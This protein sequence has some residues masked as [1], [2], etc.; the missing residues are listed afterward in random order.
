LERAKENHLIAAELGHVHSMVEFSFALDESDPLHWYWFGK[1]TRLGFSRCSPA[2]IYNAVKQVEQLNAGCGSAAVVFQ[3][4][5]ALN[6]QIDVEKRLIFGETEDGDHWG[7]PEQSLIPFRKLVGP[8][9]DAISFYTIQL[10]ACRR[11][12]DCWSSV[13]IRFRVV[14]D[15][16]IL[17]G[18]M[19]WETRE[20]AL[21]PKQ[22]T[23]ALRA[24]K[25]A[26]K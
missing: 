17:I 26:R 21:F 19:I 2:F 11:A 14:K 12:V 1:A 23:R 20:L 16:R 13:G 5:L 15:I 18:K 25:R 24:L 4:G 10:A 7:L 9:N 6:G 8:A 3:I 22:S